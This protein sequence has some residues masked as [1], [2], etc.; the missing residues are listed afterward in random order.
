MRKLYVLIILIFFVIVN[1]YSQNSSGREDTITNQKYKLI[2]MGIIIS[3]NDPETVWNALR[4]ANFSLAENDTVSIFLIGKGVEISNI[5]D[6]EFDVA[7]QLNDF[8]DK[9]GN[10]LACGTC[11]RI[12]KMEGTKTCPVS[13]LSD[14]YNLIRLNEK[15]ITF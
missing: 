15:I 10:I 8:I 1:I 11:M 14:L 12:R 6:K 4:L 7:S 5:S 13:S 9:G 3:T 2:K